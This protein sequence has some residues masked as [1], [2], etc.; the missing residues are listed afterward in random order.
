VSYE[1]LVRS[2]EADGQYYIFTCQCGVPGCIGITAGITV[3][4]TDTITHWHITDPVQQT[5]VFDR[6]K[7]LDK[8]QLVRKQCIK[9]IKQQLLQSDASVEFEIFDDEHLQALFDGLVTPTA[10]G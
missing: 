3:N 2:T 10:R 7:L 4:H 9:L 6:Y 1:Q 8:V 5:F